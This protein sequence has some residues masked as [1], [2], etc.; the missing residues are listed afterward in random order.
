MQLE[1]VQ[2]LSQNPALRGKY[3]DIYYYDANGIKEII[4]VE[5]QSDTNN[6]FP[7]LDKQSIDDIKFSLKNKLMMQ[8]ISNIYNSFPDAELNAG[9]IREA[10]ANTLKGYSND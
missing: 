5:T 10:N 8:E 7:S 9:Y 1:T 2:I 3:F 6:I 4:S